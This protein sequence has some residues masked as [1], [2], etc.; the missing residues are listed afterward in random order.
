MARPITLFEVDTH[1]SRMTEYEMA[2]IRRY[3]RVPDFVQFCLPG[4]ADVLT[5]PPPGLIAVYRDYFTRGLQLSLHP[6]VC[7]G[8]LNLEVSL[9]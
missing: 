2:L 1:D 9:L 6:F 3:Y 7:E 4:P 5:R 8:L